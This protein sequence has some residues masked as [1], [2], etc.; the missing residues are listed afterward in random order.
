MQEETKKQDSSDITEKEVTYS[1]LFSFTDKVIDSANSELKR[2]SVDLYNA[3]LSHIRQLIYL[4]ITVATASAGVIVSTPYWDGNFVGISFAQIFFF[5]IL[6]LGFLL[7]VVSFL[8][9]IC[10]LRGGDIPIVQERY[11]ELIDQAYAP[12]G[13]C[14]SQNAKLD[15]LIKIDDAIESYRSK[16]SKKACKIRKLN[17]M[18]LCAGC[19]AAF[20]VLALFSTTL[21]NNYE[22]QRE[23]KIN[24]NHLQGTIQTTPGKTK[25]VE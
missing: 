23:F 8:Y 4:S 13:E 21:W 25:T 22:Q 2:L 9:G 17:Q 1:E 6:C 20:A 15:Y 12:D 16:I 11:G 18:I 5:V 19:C 10:S 24:S 3:Q 14:A 7:S